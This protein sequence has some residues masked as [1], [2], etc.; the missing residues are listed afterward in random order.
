MATITCPKC[1]T[2]RESHLRYCRNCGFEPDAAGEMGTRIA[3]AFPAAAATPSGLPGTVYV[4]DET[5]DLLRRSVVQGFGLGLGFC[6]AGIL[7]WI[8]LIVL[9]GS[10]IHF[11]APSPLG[12]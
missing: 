11:A 6:L 12:L 10:L 8:V 4:Q 2:V 1:G 9:F 7:F 3:P 5:P